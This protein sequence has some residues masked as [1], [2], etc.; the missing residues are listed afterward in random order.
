MLGDW[1][2]KKNLCHLFPPLRSKPN[3]DRHCSTL[4][5]FKLLKVLF[6]F[7]FIP[8]SFHRFFFHFIAL[9]FHCFILCIASQ[10]INVPYF[11][12]VDT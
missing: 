10:S 11:E 12:R 6:F 8:F 1:P 4:P 3:H 9:N 2:K 7:H 5:R